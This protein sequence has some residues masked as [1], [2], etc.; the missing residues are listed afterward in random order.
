MLEVL[1]V[2]HWDTRA[3]A[4]MVVGFKNDEDAANF[5]H[6]LELMLAVRHDDFNDVPGIS[7]VWGE[8]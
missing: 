4:V 3:P 5:A 1:S 2:E 8:A 6:L 7:T